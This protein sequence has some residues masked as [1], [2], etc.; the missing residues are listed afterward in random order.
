ME[1]DLGCTGAFDRDRAEHSNIVKE[2]LV[3]EPELNPA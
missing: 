1:W 3:I 2:K